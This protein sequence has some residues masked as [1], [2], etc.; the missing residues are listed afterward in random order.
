MNRKKKKIIKPDFAAFFSTVFYCVTLSWKA[1]RFYTLV[2]LLGR[3]IIP[4]CGIIS[5]YLVKY[6]LDLLTDSWHVE[7]K[8]SMLITLLSGTLILALISAGVQKVVQY[9]QTIHGEILSKQITMQLMDKTLEADL[10]FFDNPEYYNKLSVASRD[11]LSIVNILWNVLECMSSCITFVGAFAVL[12]GSNV[13]YGLA[14]LLA[15]FPSAIAG[16]KFTKSLYKLSLDQIKGERK[17]AYIQG[18]SSSRQ[19]SQDIRLFGAGSYLKECYIQLWHSLFDD[20]R[21]ILRKRSI[22]TGILEFL[23]EIV[24]IGI[25]VDV[26]FRVL[27]SNATIGDYTLYAGLARQLY[28]SIFTF[29][30]SAIQIY[31]DKLRINNIKTLD[32]FINR[33]ANTGL[34]KLKKVGTIEFCCVSFCYP[35]SKRKVLDNVS[36]KVDKG[37]KVALVGI[38]GSGKSTLIK[39]LL[40]FYDVDSGAIKINGTDIREF[41]LHSLRSNFS[42]YFQDMLNYSF[43]LRENLKIADLGRED[44]DGPILQAINESC[45]DDILDK[46]LE[47]LDTYISRMFEDSGI[48]LSCGQHQKIAIARAFYRRHTALILD[49]PSSSLDSEAEH[50]VFEALRQLSSGKTTLFTSH[51]L[52]NVGLADRIIVLEDGRVIEQGTQTELLNNPNRFAKLFK[53]QQDKF[54]EVAK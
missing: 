40:R 46:A 12:S 27:A 18:L 38:N 39:L 11:S 37:E 53:Y 4:I 42:V 26:S 31:D 34:K 14:V 33:V 47:K 32:N 22:L 36:F 48:E 54:M 21:K 16:A 1:S 8:I 45:S 5:S 17:K 49:E 24:V 52:S 25:A 35:G 15:A 23:P 29:S 19:Y 3:I 10:E 30:N 43:T 2:R 6:I 20:R 51:R 9:C 44:G 50:K 28:S 7:N 13:Y 41:D